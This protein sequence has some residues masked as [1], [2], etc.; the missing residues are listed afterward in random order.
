MR[1]AFISGVVEWN[2]GPRVQPVM[3]LLCR[4]ALKVESPD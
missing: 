2:A 4:E 1:D 3:V